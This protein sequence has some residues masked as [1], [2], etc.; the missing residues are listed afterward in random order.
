[1]LYYVHGYNGRNGN[2]S[3]M[4]KKEL[5]AICLTYDVNSPKESLNKL[6]ER[7]LKSDEHPIIIAS[8]LG[9]WFAEQIN[10][11][12]DLI[13]YNP[14]LNPEKTLSRY[15]VHDSVRDEYGIVSLKHH[16]TKRVVILSE[17]DEIL[18]PQDAVWFYSN[19]SRIISTLGGHRMTPSNFALIKKEKEYLECLV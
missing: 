12:K 11:P 14:S 5:N 4:M 16:S 13:L 17:D 6:E 15:G 8:S 7:I 19:K 10:L 18:N 9:C 2:T 1:M 3:K